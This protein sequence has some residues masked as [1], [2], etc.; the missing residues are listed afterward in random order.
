MLHV[1]CISKLGEQGTE[2][3]H[4]KQTLFLFLCV[5]LSN[6]PL[7]ACSMFLCHTE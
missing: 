1:S 4:T 5:W 7:Y 6:I 2:E 3:R